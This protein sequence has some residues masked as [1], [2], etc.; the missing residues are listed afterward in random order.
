MRVNSD[1]FVVYHN[2]NG[3]DAQMV[4]SNIDQHTHNQEIQSNIIDIGSNQWNSSILLHDSVIANINISKEFTNDPSLD[5][6]K[7]M[8][9]KEELDNMGRSF[10]KEMK[11]QSE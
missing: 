9:S 6:D 1:V 3:I 11:N 2:R 5:F 8:Q 10:Y 4:D 7:E